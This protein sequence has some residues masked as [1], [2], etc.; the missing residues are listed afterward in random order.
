MKSIGTSS[1]QMRQA[2][3]KLNE[4]P[5]T[6]MTA[7][8]FNIEPNNGQT[9]YDHEQDFL[10][11]CAEL[12]SYTDSPA[13]AAA[14][15][16]TTWFSQLR[17]RCS[18]IRNW[19]PKMCSCLESGTAF[20]SQSVGNY[21]RLTGAKG[22][23]VFEYARS[24]NKQQA[25]VRFADSEQ[26]DDTEQDEQKIEELQLYCEDET[27]CKMI[28]EKNL[29]TIDLCELV[30]VKK[31]AVGFNWSIVEIWPELGMERTVEDHEDI[32][33]VCTEKT[34][35]SSAKRSRKFLF[36]EDFLKYE[37]FYDPREFFPAEMIDVPAIFAE[38]NRPLVETKAALRRYL[39]DEE[40]ECPTIF[41]FVWIQIGR[42]HVWRRIHLLLRDRKLYQAKKNTKQ[43]YPFAQLSD[44]AVYR[45]TNA[46][47]RFKAPYPWGICLRPT[48]SHNAARRTED[49]SGQSGEPG[50]KVI[51]F[52]S[53]KSRAC[54]LTAMRLAKYG[55][56][57]RE[58]YRAFKNK[59]CEQSEN[60]K[61]RYVNYNVS[62]E[63]VRSLVAM[64]FTGSV[65]RI[66]EDPKEAKNIAE[67]EGVNWRRTWRPFS[68]PP[69]GCAVVRLHGLDDACSSF[70]RARAIWGRTC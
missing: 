46:R 20:L 63:S 30:K 7:S 24:T 14:D 66:V 38:N 6:T 54:W 8:S 62:N 40:V 25:R 39:E 53:E 60:S 5:L 18:R 59:Q 51:A 10:N 48:S 17:Q 34:T 23:N 35:V 3:L 13:A 12:A 2:K 47:R 22:N 29:R 9:I 55:K 26:S 41:S 67:S 56:Q 11:S 43:V 70:A 50:L 58:N 69:P 68:R 45:I 28:V 65:G 36:R 61:D 37:F 57:L 44:Y 21:Q 64:D 16:T 1:N 15:C 27:L 49:E 31:C 4:L 19:L 32:F 42:L 33:A 52:H